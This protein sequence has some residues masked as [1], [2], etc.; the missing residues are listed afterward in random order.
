MNAFSSE[1]TRLFGYLK[2]PQR[3]NCS[4]TVEMCCSKS[5]SFQTF[6]PLVFLLLYVS[7]CDCRGFSFQNF[8]SRR[9]PDCE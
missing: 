1:E 5:L 8:P 3:W 2:K 7:I 6:M 9:F 4:H